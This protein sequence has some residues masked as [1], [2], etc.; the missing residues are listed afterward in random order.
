MEMVYDDELTCEYCGDP[1]TDD[2]DVTLNT[3]N[4]LAYHIKCYKIWQKWLL[5]QKI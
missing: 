2:Q 4:M 1:I 5:T 3:D